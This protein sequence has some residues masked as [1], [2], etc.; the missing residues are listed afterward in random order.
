MNARGRILIVD[1]E[2]NIR[3][4]C[5]RT[6]R[7][8]DYAV[9]TAADASAG[10]SK[11]AARGADVVIT[12]LKMPGEMDGR[13]FT[14]EI[15]QRWPATDVL[16]MTAYPELETAIPTLRSGACDYLSK[17]FSPDFLLSIVERCFEKRRLSKELRR[18]QRLR[19]ELTAAYGELQKVE[20][21]KEAILSRL[22]HELRAPTASCL[23]ALDALAKGP[24]DPSCQATLRDNLGKLHKTVEDMILYATF[25][26][27]YTRQMRTSVDPL[28]LIHHALAKHRALIDEK[29]IC[30]DVR[31]DAAGAQ[32][33]AMREHMQTA[34]NHLIMNAISFNRRRGRIAIAGRC[35][36][37][38]LIIT[39]SDTGIGIPKAKL[40]NIFDAFYQAADYLSREVGGLGL[41]LAIVRKVAEAHGG[42]IFVKSE[43]GQGTEFTLRLPVRAAT[44]V[45]R[46]SETT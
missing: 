9:D 17:P 23:L 32:V 2:P 20:R 27:S 12:D 1:D 25:P 40:S 38:D 34:L 7:G 13:Q 22:C 3:S 42:S 18:E 16:I 39:I 8:V 19:A 43:E 6:F 5:E 41:G 30:V 4:V 15:R 33:W 37:R 29:E 24:A 28:N 10:L 21:L 44:V 11:L 46:P 45:A 31:W 36:P 26:N 14:E 35:A